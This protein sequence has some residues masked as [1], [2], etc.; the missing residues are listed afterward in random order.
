MLAMPT[1]RCR[2]RAS[3]AN[4]SAIAVA[5]AV[6]CAALTAC[7]AATRRSATS[8]EPPPGGDPP[9]GDAVPPSTSWDLEAATQ[10]TPGREMPFGQVE[11]FDADDYADIVFEESFNDR[12]QILRRTHVTA[13]CYSGGCARFDVR[14]GYTAQGDTGILLQHQN[15]PRINLGYMIYFGRDWITTMSGSGHKH[16]LVYDDVSG[17]GRNIRPMIAES[18]VQDAG[19]ARAYRIFRA[20]NNAA[21]ICADEFGFHFPT[22]APSRPHA[23]TIDEHLE[24]WLYVEFEVVTGGLNTLYVWSRDGTLRSRAGYCDGGVTAEGWDCSNINVAA[25]PLD[26]SRIL[27]YF[28]DR[29]DNPVTAHSYVLIDNLRVDDAFMGPPAGFV[30]AR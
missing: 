6:L 22:A 14:P 28:G 4:P 15:G 7:D 5:V 21:G 26:Y 11:K 1:G 17:G 25:Q 30:A 2:T 24:E 9:G 20:C 16:V 13:G 3:A 8:P 23:F 19:G 12:A 29:P 18:D 10:R 27:A